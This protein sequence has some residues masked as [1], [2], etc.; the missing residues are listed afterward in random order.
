MLVW[1]GWIYKNFVRNRIG[2]LLENQSLYVVRNFDKLCRYLIRVPHPIFFGLLIHLSTFRHPFRPQI[3]LFFVNPS[4]D[5]G[6]WRS[7]LKVFIKLQLNFLVDFTTGIHFFE[8]CS[9]L[10][11][12]LRTKRAFSKNYRIMSEKKALLSVQKRLK[13]FRY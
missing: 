4:W 10:S 7:E 2:R 12:F 13:H 6:Y 3:T 11:L 8:E 1:Q 9:F 5:F